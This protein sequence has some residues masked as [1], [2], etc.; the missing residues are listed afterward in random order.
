MNSFFK[1][2]IMCSLLLSSLSGLAQSKEVVAVLNDNFQ[3]INV[4]YYLYPATSN[5]IA[6][7]IVNRINLNDRVKALSVC[8]S[9][10]NLKKNHLLP[11]GVKFVE[12]YKYTYN[13]NYDALRLISD[14][15]GVNYILLV[16][17]G[18]DI[19]SSFLKQTIWNMLNVP[20][21]DVVN[22]QYRVVTRITLI[23]PKNEFIVFQKNYNKYIASKEFDLVNQGYAPVY[24]QMS[25]IKKYS[26]QLALQVTPLVETQIVPELMPVQTTFLEKVSSKFLRKNSDPTSSNI[27]I[28]SNPKL[29]LY[30]YVYEDL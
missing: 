17:S 4:N 3:P 29:K 23:D 10:N 5:L 13:I 7:D 8:N 16:T 19:Q 24:P 30:N 25:R 26:E 28:E 15:L 12:E 2:T 11:Q 9:I 21:E 20:G 18:L 1:I 22:P 6:Q 14:K 27:K